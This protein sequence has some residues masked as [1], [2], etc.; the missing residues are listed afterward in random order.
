[1]WELC[2]GKHKVYDLPYSCTNVSTEICTP[3]H[4][5]ASTLN[6]H[7]LVR[8]KIE[9]GIHTVIHF[10]DSSNGYE[11]PVS[12]PIQKPSPSSLR[13]TIITLPL[14]CPLPPSPTKPLNSIFQCL[15][16]LASMPGRK[17]I[18]KKLDYDILLIEEVNFLPPRFDGNRM[19]VLPSIGV[20][21]SHTKA[22]SMDG[23]DKRYDGHVWTKTQ[24]TN[25]TNDIGLAFRLSTCVGHLECQ[26]PHCDYLQRAHRTSLVNDTN[27]DGFIKEFFFV[28][29][30]L[31]LG[32]TLMC[33][34]C[35]E[36]SMYVASCHTMSPNS[37]SHMGLGLD[38]IRVRIWI[39]FK[40][41]KNIKNSD[42]I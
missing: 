34:M 38:V 42:R 5:S 39:Y 33:K 8:V 37:C 22:K 31:P 20:S 40:H 17:N 19:F 28:G 15:R 14:V 25:I 30:P 12:T 4:S 32:S 27:F 24:I 6:T 26:N 13:S 9:P 18:L 1:M 10:S 36:P 16:T 3:P 35:K 7:P 29:S 41:F 23:M 2:A 21:S 11:P